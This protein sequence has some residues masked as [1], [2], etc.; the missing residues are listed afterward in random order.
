M[1]IV[2]VI[3]SNHKLLKIVSSSST[4]QDRQ[5]PGCASAPS[6]AQAAHTC[7][8]AGRPVAKE[9]LHSQRL[10]FHVQT[11]EQYCP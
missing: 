8:S 9:T 6:P 4:A 5:P 7:G 1:L 11:G 2:S 3:K 10:P